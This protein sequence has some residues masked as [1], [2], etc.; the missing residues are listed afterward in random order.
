[1]LA[2]QIK[3]KVYTY[4]ETVQMN[5]TPTQKKILQQIERDIVDAVGIAESL[6]VPGSRVDYLMGELERKGYIEG[7]KSCNDIGEKEYIS[8]DL[9]SKGRTALEAPQELIDESVQTINSISFTTESINAPMSFIQDV[10]GENSIQVSQS[11]SVTNEISEIID[12]IDILRQGTIDFPEPEREEAKLHLNELK[13]EI[14]KPEGK[15]IKIRASFNSFLRVAM[16]VAGLIV[17]GADF[18]NN[19]TDLA[20]K[21]DIALSPQQIEIFQQGSVLSDIS[22]FTLP[23]SLE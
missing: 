14:Q 11:S 5:L 23:N 18:I 21:F 22:D 1:M 12:K 17:G 7:V 8:S 19:L 3:T 2:P 4:P 9:T 10:D 15:P 20:E 16:S 6:G 13:E